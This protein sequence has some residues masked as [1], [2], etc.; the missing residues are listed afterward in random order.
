MGAFLLL[1]TKTTET[2]AQPLPEEKVEVHHVY[3]PIIIRQTAMQTQRD[4]EVVKIV[5]ELRAEAEKERRG[6]SWILWRI[7]KWMRIKR[8]RPSGRG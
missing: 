7:L 8:R 3:L 1:L 4:E 2:P 6:C 5:Q